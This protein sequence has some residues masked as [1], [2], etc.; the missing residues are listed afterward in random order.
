[1]DKQHI[2][3]E[4][5][6][7]AR[8]NGG[9]PLGQRA[10]VTAT[11]L[12]ISDWRGRHWSRWGD[13]LV[14]AGFPPNQPKV[15]IEDEV[16]VDQY[17]ALVRR[18]GRLPTH[19]ELTLEGRRTPGFPSMGAFRRRGLT[20]GGARAAYLRD[21]CRARGAGFDD[22]VALCEAALDGQGAPA[23]DPSGAET[24][25]T[26]YLMKM[27]SYYKIGRSSAFGRRGRDIALQLPERA[28]AVHVI[29]TDD[30]VGIEAYWHR[31]FADRRQNGEWFA[32]SPADVRAF[33]RRKTFM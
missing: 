4:I 21:R 23:R 8:T 18:L 31:R 22:I 2:L 11:G 25:G 19:S 10:F 14:E 15:A 12:K 32:L 17:V 3:N 6:R 13:A 7:T 24:P 26:V 29:E 33:R 30:V 20:L 27:G 28:V 16:I 9:V 1:M 5:R